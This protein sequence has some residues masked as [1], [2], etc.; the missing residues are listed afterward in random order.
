MGHRVSTSPRRDAFADPSWLRSIDRPPD[1]SVRVHPPVLCLLFGVPSLSLPRLVSRFGASAA[2]VSVP[3]IA[4]S[5]VA[6]TCAG[7]PDLP[8][9][10]ALRLSRPLDGFLRFRLR[11]LVS[12]RD[13]V[14]G[15]SVQGL[16]PIRGHPGSSPGACLLDV[17]ALR[18]RRPKPM[19]ARR[20]PRPRGF[21][22]RI[23][24]LRL[25]PLPSS[26]SSSFRC[27]PLLP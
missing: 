9:G 7:H 24:A 2:R 17:V 20:A 8:L 16:L 27:S 25:R 23:D 19:F 1:C 12:S 11:G 22:P 3:F 13:H 4:I 15:F 10:S 21:H 14:Q 26:D 18:A 5:P 6:F